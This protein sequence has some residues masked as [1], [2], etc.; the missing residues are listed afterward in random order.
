MFALGLFLYLKARP[1]I[2]EA[3]AAYGTELPWSL[4]VA[5]S[6]AFLP[7]TMGSSALLS[8]LAL[9]LPIGRGRRTVLLGG[10]L[11]LSAAALVFAVWSAFEPMFHALG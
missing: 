8:L 2:L 11:V 4:R 7:G 6:D 9:V 3:F 5:L 1:A 10:A